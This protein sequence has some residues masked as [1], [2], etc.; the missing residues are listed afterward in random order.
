MAASQNGWV[1]NQR[2]KVASQLVPGTNTKLTVRKDAPGL[3]LLEVASAFDRL[4]A[5]IDENYNRGA[6]DDWGYAERPI[7]GG[8]DLSNHASGTAID[9]N[10]TEHPLGKSGTFSAEQVA[11]IHQIVGAT[12]DVVRWGGDYSGR[13]DEMHFE[14]NDGMTMAQC[15]AAL[16]VLREFNACG[17]PADPKPSSTPKPSAKVTVLKNGSRGEAVKKLQAFMNRVYPRYSK[18]AVDGIFG[19]HTEI[20]VE[21]FQRRSK[22]KVDGVVGPVTLAKMGLKL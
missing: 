11:K 5:D 9:L 21:E 19:Y 22:I 14:I 16:V 15:E 10:A 17:T 7:R 4:V 2:S 8:A 18:L 20:A 3:L 13:K 12:N 6:L 1:A